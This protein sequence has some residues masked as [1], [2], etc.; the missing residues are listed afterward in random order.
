MTE[1]G[2]PRVAV[3]GGNTVDLVTYVG[4]AP[5][6]GRPT[7]VTVL[8][9]ARATPTLEV[10]RIRDVTLFAASETELT[11]LTA[12]AGATESSAAAAARSLLDKGSQTL[13]VSL[14]SRARFLQGP[15]GASL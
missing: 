13:I 3:V 2:K 14:G 15:G 9:P 12:M 8:A 11:V 1:M 7:S 6:T 5:V 10:N 4:R